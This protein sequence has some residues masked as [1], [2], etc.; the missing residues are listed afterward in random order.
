MGRA[1]VLL[2]AA[3]VAFAAAASASVAPTV[4]GALPGVR[5]TLT[6]AERR[7]GAVVVHRVLVR[8]TGARRITL[9]VGRTRDRRLCVGSGAFFRCLGPGDTQPAYVIGSF[10]GAASQQQPV[11]GAAVGLAGSAIRE[12]DAEFQPGMRRPIQLRR[13]PGF[14]WRVFAYAPRGPNGDLPYRIGLKAVHGHR[15]ISLDLAYAL[16]Q[17]RRPG[18]CQGS[19]SAV[20]D[21]VDAPIGETSPAMKRAK[22]LALTDPRVQRILGLSPHV[23]RAASPWTSCGGQQLG[24][25]VSVELFRAVAVHGRLP[26]ITLGKAKRGRVYAEGLARLNVGRVTRLHVAVDLARGRIVSI[27]PSGDNL[28]VLAHDVVRPPVPVGAPDLV[29]CPSS[30]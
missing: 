15:P 8:R 16:S 29:A 1:L 26:F 12:I 19:W 17:C 18:A 5:V 25:Y 10:A 11:W 3:A 2:F 20:G 14:P 21:S 30:G 6:T 4:P 13:V 23:V 27:D 7:A 28:R 9:L 24:A 22:R